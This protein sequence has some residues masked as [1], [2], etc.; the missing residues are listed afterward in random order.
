MTTFAPRINSVRDAPGDQGG[1]VEIEFTGAYSELA[2]FTPSIMSY[3]VW[4]KIVP[5]V[6]A[7]AAR[8]G[9]RV[10]AAGAW[11]PRTILRRDGSW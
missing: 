9:S 6:P 8:N 10:E 2:P 11:G 3:E 1:K 5:T 4:R 7:L